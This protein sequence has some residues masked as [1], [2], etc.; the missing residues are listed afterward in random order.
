VRTQR[1]L[2]PAPVQLNLVSMSEPSLHLV[3][4]ARLPYLLAT[5]AGTRPPGELWPVLCFLHGYDEGAPAPIREALTRH[6]PLRPGNSTA[7]RGFI[8]VAPQLPA[9]GDIWRQHADA[10]RDMVRD[11]QALHGG[12]GERTFLTGFSYGGNGV[13]DLALQQRGFWA[14]LWA[15]DPTRAP[16]ADPA[17]PVWLSSGEVSRRLESAF[18]RQ[19][20]LVDGASS[21]DRVIVDDGLDHVGTAAAAYASAR[22][23]EWLLSR[24]L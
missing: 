1:R 4:S 18:R 24:V 13:F 6:G 3:E 20:D 15:V 11:V 5:P 2:H 7:A 23:Y 17:L 19:L 12:D 16:G 22:P 21:G 14:A 10:V 9:R 8:T